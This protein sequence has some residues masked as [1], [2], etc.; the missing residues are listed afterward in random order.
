VTRP[1]LALAVLAAGT[2]LPAS[3]QPAAEAPSLRELSL[4][5]AR[6]DFRAP[7]ICEI[8]GEPHRGLRR[9]M[10]G[11]GPRREHEPVN[12]VTLYDLD[13]PPDTRCSSDLR[14]EEPNAVGTLTMSFDGRRRPDTAQH[15]FEQAL[16]R[17]GGFSFVIR[18]GKLR[19]GASGVAVAALPEVDFAGGEA[20][21]RVIARGSDA[22]RTLSG[23]A[24]ARRM[25]LTLAAPDGTRL[26]FPL[27]QL[28][29]P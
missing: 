27:V 12:R 9:V 15:D 24:G 16:R 23:L 5:W 25:L 3:G 13:V 19:L 17:E 6:G 1:W 29:G 7:V 11:P 2:A 20:S 8:E 14:P 21:L 10:I 22:E 28:S 26:E 18:A 4:V